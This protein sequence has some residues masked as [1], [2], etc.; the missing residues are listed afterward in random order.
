[1]TI[2]PGL[3]DQIHPPTVR[4]TQDG[5]TAKR[6]T[7]DNDQVGG[8]SLGNSPDAI[9]HAQYLGLTQ[10][11]NAVD[12]GLGRRDGACRGRPS[13]IRS[14]VAVPVG[15]GDQPAQGDRTDLLGPQQDRQVTEF[16]LRSEIFTP[17]E[18]LRSAT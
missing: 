4:F 11:C 13:R 8:E 10:P 1:M 6:I 12:F 5:E 3:H 2:T 18:I 9:L 17:G 15:G 7:V 14:R 16:S